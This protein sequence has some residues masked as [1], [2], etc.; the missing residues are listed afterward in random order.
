MTVGNV[1]PPFDDSTVA[2]Y[3]PTATTFEAVENATDSRLASDAETSDP[4]M[5]PSVVRTNTLLSPS[6]ARGV[7][8]RQCSASPHVMWVRAS[9][10]VPDGKVSGSAVQ[11]MPS[12]VL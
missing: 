4:V 3:S 12:S 1:A 8:I 10:E 6:G 7:V 2:P 9:G 5:P 11:L